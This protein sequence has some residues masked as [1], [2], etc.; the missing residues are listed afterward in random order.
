M[1]EIDHD[2]IFNNI[3]DVDLETLKNAYKDLCQINIDVQETY[4]KLRKWRYW[5]N[6]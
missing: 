1:S 4:N 2:Q 3:D 6:R 5:I